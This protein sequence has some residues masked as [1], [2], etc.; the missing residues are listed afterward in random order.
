VRERLACSGSRHKYDI[1]V[2]VDISDYKKFVMALGYQ[3]IT[4]YT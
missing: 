1:A 3:R 2:A 4:K